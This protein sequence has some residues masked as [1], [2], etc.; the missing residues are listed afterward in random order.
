MKLVVVGTHSNI[1]DVTTRINIEI[2]QLYNIAFFFH[3][4]V[5]YTIAKTIINSENN[6]SRQTITTLV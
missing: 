2:S 3:N 4:S 1:N 6:S 5:E